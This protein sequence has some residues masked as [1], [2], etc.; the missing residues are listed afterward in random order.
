MKRPLLFKLRDSILSSNGFFMRETSGYM[1]LMITAR[2]TRGFQA[3][4]EISCFAAGTLRGVALE[5]DSRVTNVVFF[6]QDMGQR[7]QDGRTIARWQVIDE[8]VT[9]ES[10]HA[11]G[12]A[13]DMQIMNFKHATD[14]IH[15]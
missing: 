3:A 14:S 9:G 15:I 10:G 6:V 7:L 13:P 4:V 11:T 1:M 12:N 5:L 8:H 2:C